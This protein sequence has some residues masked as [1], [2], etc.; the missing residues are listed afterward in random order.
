MEVSRLRKA[1]EAVKAK[2]QETSD[3]SLEAQSLA[4][5]AQGIA[6]MAGAGTSG[7]GKQHPPEYAKEGYW[8]ERYR[9][10]GKGLAIASSEMKTYEWY[11]GYKDIRPL[12]REATRCD[13]K[14]SANNSTE[15]SSLC[16]TL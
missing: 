11:Q 5:K 12:V 15:W 7:G 9:P 14:V 8:E 13:T 3:E 16:D 10:G 6:A 2:L 1:Q 4:A